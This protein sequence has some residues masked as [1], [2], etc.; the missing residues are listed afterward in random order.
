MR[1]R[2]HTATGAGWSGSTAAM[3]SSLLLAV[4]APAAPA[5]ADEVQLKDG[6][7]LEGTVV[8]EPDAPTVR[9][10]VPFGSVQIPRE[11]IERITFGPT[12]EEMYVERARQTDVSDPAAVRELASW[13]RRHGLTERARELERT[14]LQIELEQ[15]LEHAELHEG[16]DGLVQTARWA[17]QAGLGREVVRRIYERALELSPGHPG[18][19]AGLALLEE[20]ERQEEERRE[21]VR[22]RMEER[23]L[24]LEQERAE[25]ERLRQERLARREEERRAAAAERLVLGYAGTWDAYPLRDP[26]RYRSAS[27]CYHHG[28]YGC[29]CGGSAYSYGVYVPYHGWVPWYQG[30]FRCGAGRGPVMGLQ[31]LPRKGYRLGR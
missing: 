17:E 10:V 16:A 14:A 1:S 24:R 3:L 20:Q 30:A 22:R 9:L 18:A 31:I 26:Y 25:A 4:F 19:L 15:R 29:G 21:Q 13:A 11:Q 12:A 5:V 23:R 28:V 6:T 2:K 7:V 8:L 27:Y